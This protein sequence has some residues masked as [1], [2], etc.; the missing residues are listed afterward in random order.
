MRSL[1][2]SLGV[3]F[4]STSYL[5][6][7]PDSAAPCRTR[8]AMN[9]HGPIGDPSIPGAGHTRRDLEVPSRRPVALEVGILR[10]RQPRISLTLHVS[11]RGPIARQPRAP[12][13]RRSGHRTAGSQSWP[14]P[15]RLGLYLV[16]HQ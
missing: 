2:Y 12:D 14:D 4:T 7:D 11:I 6:A 9:P 13:T 16:R 15:G 8:S 3:R 1:S 5:R 10:L